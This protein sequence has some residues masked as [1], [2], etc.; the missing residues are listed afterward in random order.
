MKIK[1]TAKALRSGAYHPI[2]IGY[3][4][5]QYLLW[6]KS[7]TAY[8]SGVYGWNADVYILDNATIITGYRRLVGERP[9]YKTL[10]RLEKQAEKIVNNWDLTI[11]QKR[12]KLD[13]LLNKLIV[14]VY[15]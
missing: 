10:E 6:H 4:N 7:A 8:T 11:D 9:D 14:S 12:S 2:A 5:A 3:C 1:T 15:G 13:K